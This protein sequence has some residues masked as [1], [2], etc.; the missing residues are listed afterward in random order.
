[1][2]QETRTLHRETVLAAEAPADARR[3]FIKR[4]YA[5]LAV[6]VLAFVGLEYLLLNSP[7]AP[8][9]MSVVGAS[10]WGWLLVLV[11]FM[12]VA[13]LAERWARSSA[14]PG[15]QY[16]GLAVYVVAEAIIFIPLLYIATFYARYEGLLATAA[17]ITAV[18]FAGL[19]A[20]VFLTKHD[21]S[22]MRG[23]LYAGGLAAMA[24]LLASLIFG[25]NLGTVYSGALVLLASGYVVY[26]T[27]QI[28]RAYP[29]GS[30]VAASLALFASVAL[31][32]WYIL[33]ILMDRR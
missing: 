20:I 14:S 25:F 28:L 1:M 29:V 2:M 10:R 15:M 3:E 16:L 6:A 27:S 11:A 5:H 18:V 22:W 17:L 26:H 21:F 7:V 33:R 9:V 12:A 8:K 13:W 32:F 4:T 30:H 24:V 19:T 23:I 31:L